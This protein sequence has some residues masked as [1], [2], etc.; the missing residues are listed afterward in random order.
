MATATSTNIIDIDSIE[1][2]LRVLEEKLLG[3]G[4]GNESNN[5]YDDYADVLVYH[6]ASRIEF[7]VV[8]IKVDQEILRTS[9]ILSGISLAYLYRELGNGFQFVVFKNGKFAAT[10]DY[11][12]STFAL[13]GGYKELTL[14]NCIELEEGDK[15]LFFSTQAIDKFDRDDYPGF[16]FISKELL[17]ELMGM[18]LKTFLDRQFMHGYKPELDRG[19][20]FDSTYNSVLGLPYRTEYTNFQFAY[21]NYS[22]AESIVKWHDDD[23]NYSTWGTFGLIMKDMKSKVSTVKLTDSDKA[24]LNRVLTSATMAINEEN[25]LNE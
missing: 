14:S 9:N 13:E 8:K 18:D 20:M 6:S 12:W 16:G 11:M 15:L 3:S 5:S 19:L 2:R 7:N 22:D 23:Y 25:S 4:D 24:V 21:N 1:V 10:T 17:K